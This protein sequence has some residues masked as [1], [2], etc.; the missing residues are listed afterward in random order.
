MFGPGVTVKSEEGA[1][2]AARNLPFIS[3]AVFYH[4]HDHVPSDS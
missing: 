1:T 4:K 3:S 2:S